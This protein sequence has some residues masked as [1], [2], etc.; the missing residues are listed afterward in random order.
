MIVISKTDSDFV[1][2]KTHAAVLSSFISMSFL[3]EL[4]KIRLICKVLSTNIMVSG[5]SQSYMTC[6]LCIIR[7]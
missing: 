3:C 7:F 5:Y 1:A 6:C 2:K 4:V